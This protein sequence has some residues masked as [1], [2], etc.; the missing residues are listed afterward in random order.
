MRKGGAAV[1]EKEDI[2]EWKIGHQDFIKHNQ[3]NQASG[4]TIIKYHQNH[5]EEAIDVP[6]IITIIHMVIIIITIDH[7]YETIILPT[8][9]FCYI[10]V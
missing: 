9:I 6:K 10:L 2:F 5:I 4:K 8:L 3:S 7:L 1:L